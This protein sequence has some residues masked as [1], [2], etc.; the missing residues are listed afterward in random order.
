MARTRTWLV[1]ALAVAAVGCSTPLTTREKGALAGG[2]IGAG[3]G[4]IIGS[5]TGH[6]GAGAVIGA[7]V[8]AVSGAI[9]GDAIQGAE[10]K[11]A[12]QSPASPPPPPAVVTAPAP[13][14][15]VATPPRV[16]APQPPQY[17]WVPE[18]GM[19][20]LEGYDIVYYNGAYY[21]YDGGRWYI[22]QHYGGPWALVASPPPV[23]AKLPRGHFNRSLPPGLA[24]K[25][26]I[27]PGHMR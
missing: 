1:I 6:T 8:G 21:Y 19:Y 4:A 7:G 25:G 9:I 18:W 27:P 13:Q 3:T 23:F 22:S 5:Q 20:V 10:Q 14:V 11:K 17:V 2:A 12:A 15:A 24:K 16:V 26:K